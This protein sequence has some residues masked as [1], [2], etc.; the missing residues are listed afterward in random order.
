MILRS[1]TKHVKDQNWFAVGLDFFIVVFGVYIG[2]WV[3][4]YQERASLRAKQAQ[5]VETLRLD[6][7]HVLALDIAFTRDINQGFDDWAAKRASGE[8]I[9]PFFHRIPGSDIPPQHIW[10]TLPPNQLTDMFAPDLLFDIGFY[11]SELDGVGEKYKRYVIFVENEILPGLK[12]NP[13]YFYREDG[14]RLKPEFEANMDRL[15][16]WV[17]ENVRLRAWSACLV[18]RLGTPMKS[19]KSCTPDLS[20]SVITNPDVKSEPTKAKP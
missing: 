4:G 1:M 8:I 19:G 12:Q 14:L 17:D 20:I 11:Y 16:D 2:V 6:M 7:Q 18:K 9:P 10:S 5:V 15:Q 3:S 13:S